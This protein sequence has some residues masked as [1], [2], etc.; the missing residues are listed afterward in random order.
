MKYLVVSIKGGVGKS[1]IASNLADYINGS[2]ITND[3]VVGEHNGAIQIE[4]N[5]RKIPQAYCKID[6]A[7]YDFGAMYSQIDPKVSH[8]TKLC[9]VIIIPT[10]TDARSIQAT[11]ETYNLVNPS[12]KPI[13]IIINNYSKQKKYDESA[14]LLNEK[15]GKVTI[16][17]IRTTTLFERVAKDGREWFK[18]IHH[19][20]GEYQLNKSRIAHEGVYHAIT[21]WGA[22]L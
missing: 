22:I 15:L 20:K 10:L 4:Y 17:G 19:D 7:V 18:N 9:D 1:S 6:N 5:K 21:N 3:L 13:V 8:A 2:Y 16:Y 12:G 11:I 14:Q